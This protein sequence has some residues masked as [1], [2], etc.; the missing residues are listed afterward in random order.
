L[1][2]DAQ[3]ADLLQEYEAKIAALERMVGRA[4]VEHDKCQQAVTIPET[5]ANMA[6][7]AGYPFRRGAAAS[8][9]E[10]QPAVRPVFASFA[11]QG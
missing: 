3:A 6:T 9:H 10:S 11:V 1:D 8:A 4:S 7:P 2:E 5:H